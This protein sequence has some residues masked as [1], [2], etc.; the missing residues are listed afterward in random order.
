MIGVVVPTSLHRKLK[1]WQ[2]LEHRKSFSEFCALLLEYAERRLEKAGGLTAM[3]RSEGIAS[4]ASNSSDQD[5]IQRQTQIAK[6][7]YDQHSSPGARE[8]KSRRNKAS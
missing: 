8:S 5:L 4:D 1:A 7:V 6:G 2:A 3:L